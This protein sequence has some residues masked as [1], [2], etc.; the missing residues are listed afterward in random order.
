MSKKTIKFSS[1]EQNIKNLYGEKNVCIADPDTVYLSQGVEIGD[2]TEIEPNVFFSGKVI[3]GKNCRIRANSYLEDCV[4]EDNCVIGP[5]A[6]IRPGSLIKNEA[7]I[8]NFVEV[9]KSEIGEGSKI[10]HLSYIGDSY[11]GKNVNIGAGTITC[12][13]DGKN[14]YQTRVADGAFIGSNCCLVA[15]VNVGKNSIIGAGTTLFRDAP[16]EQVTINKKEIQSFN[17]K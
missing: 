2:N 4:I 17:K 10:N 1:L 13:Y 6:R 7:R 8:G 11:I 9:K 16:E 3:V 15:P 12:N 14:K 5:F